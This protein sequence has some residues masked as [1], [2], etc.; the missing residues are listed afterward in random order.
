MATEPS[1]QAGSFVHHL[2]GA[3]TFDAATYERIE[4]DPQASTWAAIT[5]LLASLAAG[6]G[7]GGWSGPSLG[8][9]LSVAAIALVTWVA[10]AV[11][12]FQIGTRVLPEPQTRATL[13]ELLR[14]TGFAA[15]PGLLQVFAAFPRVTVP[16]YLLT[17]L[18]MLAAMV[19]AVQ[20]ALDYQRTWRAVAVCALAASLALLLAFGIGVIWSPVVV[21]R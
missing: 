17:W 19:V 13:G 14:T 2:M 16:V 12:I 3:A 8:T 20:H 6:I 4:T 18:W 1:A 21:A 11:M 15:A 5:V 10:W 9:V 7:S